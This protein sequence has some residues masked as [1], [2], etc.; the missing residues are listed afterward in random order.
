[1]F[2]RTENG[3]YFA[4]EAGHVGLETPIPFLVLPITKCLLS[5]LPTN[6]QQWR[7]ANRYLHYDGGCCQAIV[8]VGYASYPSSTAAA[9]AASAGGAASASAAIG[10]GSNCT[11]SCGDIDIPYPFGVEPGCYHAAGF[12]LTCNH[13]YQPPMLFLGD[14]TVQVLE[15]S[16]ANG[17]TSMN[18]ILRTSTL[19]M[20][21][22][23]I[24]LEVILA[25]VL[26][27]LQ[28]MLLSQ[29][30]A[31]RSLMDTCTHTLAAQPTRVP[32]TMASGLHQF[33]KWQRLLPAVIEH[34]CGVALIDVAFGD[35]ARRRASVLGPPLARLRLRLYHLPAR[36]LPASA[37]TIY[38]RALPA[39]LHLHLSPAHRSPAS[40]STP[41]CAEEWG[42]Q[43][44]PPPCQKS[45]QDA[46]T[47][48]LLSGT[49]C[50]R[51]GRGRPR[52]HLPSCPESPPAG[53]RLL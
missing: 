35:G 48:G 47:H 3:A 36:H 11:R 8:P 37:S 31:K 12:N 34:P 5:A 33:G 28:A 45:G 18:A 29:M 6:H 41:A 49:G 32:G 38:R 4:A 25:N 52:G 44:R 10:P 15:I 40:A 53:M 43:I 2:F 16:V 7:H 51:Q 19:A 20:A 23:A 24:H 13:T 42:G 14:G 30:D 46:T 17:T 26:L 1:M 27:A 22:A 50:R 21:S 39:H 9:A